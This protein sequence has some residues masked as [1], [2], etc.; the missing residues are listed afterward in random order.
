MYTG[1]IEGQKQKYILCFTL[2]SEAYQKILKNWRNFL[3]ALE[4]CLT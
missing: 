2:I 1:I 3:R 4:R